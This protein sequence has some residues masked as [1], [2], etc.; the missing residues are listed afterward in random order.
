[1]MGSMF[2]GFGIFY[3]IILIFI[4]PVAIFI[5]AKL[6]KRLTGLN[7]KK[8][9][10]SAMKTPQ[11]GVQSLESKIITLAMNNRG[12]LTVSDVVL[13]TGLSIRQAEE[14]LNSMVDGY[15]IKMEVKDSGIIVYEF[16]ELIERK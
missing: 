16:I 14:T 4:I 12:V 3:G 5:G 2:G 7:S 8:S 6:I 1:M 10:M 11:M 9:I 15:R 13:A